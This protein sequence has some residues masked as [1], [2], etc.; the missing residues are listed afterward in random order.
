MLWGIAKI[1]Y[2]HY[3]AQVLAY[4][5]HLVILLL[6]FLFHQNSTYAHI[7]YSIL[8]VSLLIMTTLFQCLHWSLFLLLL[9]TFSC[10]LTVLHWGTFLLFVLLLGV[11]VCSYDFKFFYM[12]ITPTSFSILF[13][14][15][16]Y[17]I[18]LIVFLLL[19]PNKQT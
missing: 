12:L 9:L 6:Y 15:P 11:L 4:A 13:W 19:I 18:Y 5:R 17:S 2:T 14:A 16:E 1:R 7:H 8:A 10:T 3:L